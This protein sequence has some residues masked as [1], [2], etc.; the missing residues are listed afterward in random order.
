MRDR[1][2]VLNELDLE[3]Y[4]LKSSDSCFT[5]SSRTLYVNLYCFKT[6]LHSCSC[7]SFSS[8][9][10]CEGS[11]L[12]RASETEATCRCP[13]DSISLSICD[14]YDRIVE[15]GLDMNSAIFNILTLTTSSDSRLLSLC[16]TFV[17]LTSSC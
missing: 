9:L 17:L 13:R 3:T 5:A 12:L 14:S 2:Y 11:G 4:S 16:H 10:S 1:S 15:S 6:M 8:S 7:C